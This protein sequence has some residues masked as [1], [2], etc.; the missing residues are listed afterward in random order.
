MNVVIVDLRF[1][2]IIVRVEHD[3]CESLEVTRADTAGDVYDVIE[4][5]AY[6]LAELSRKGPV[7]L[8]LVM[9]DHVLDCANVQVEARL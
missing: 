2:P 4:A 6:K 3:G 7:A 1:L 5:A 9:P 8:Q